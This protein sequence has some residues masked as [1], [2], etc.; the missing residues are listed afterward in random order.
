M[1]VKL[2]HGR[3]GEVGAGLKEAVLRQGDAQREDP[4]NGDAGP[5]QSSRTMPLAHF[6]H[7][8]H[9]EQEDRGEHVSRCGENY[10]SPRPSPAQRQPQGPSAAITAVRPRTHQ[11]LDH[12]DREQRAGRGKAT[13]KRSRT[14]DDILGQ[15]HM[16]TPDA[17]AS[18]RPQSQR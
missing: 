12:Q 2:S 16:T 5:Q 13:H 17:P 8:E 4:L 3:T 11:A 9:S 7:D 10:A 14:E 18:T 6:N 1:G 15:P